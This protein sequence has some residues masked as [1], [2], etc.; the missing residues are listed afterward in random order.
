MGTQQTRERKVNLILK[1][2]NESYEKGKSL[3]KPTFVAHMALETGS[4]RQTVQD[5][6]ETLQLA[7]RID[8]LV[9]KMGK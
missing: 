5:I 6:I 8:P 3:D 4:S 2:L 1:T 9:W 7:G